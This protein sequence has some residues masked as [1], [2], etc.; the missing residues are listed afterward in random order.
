MTDHHDSIMIG[1]QTSLLHHTHIFVTLSPLEGAHV[2]ITNNTISLSWG[3]FMFYCQCHTQVFH[4][5]CGIH[6]AQNS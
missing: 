3:N 5:D 6:Y 4:V 1:T 2:V